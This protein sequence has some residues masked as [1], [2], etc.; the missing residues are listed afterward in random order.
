MYIPV[1]FEDA[2]FRKPKQRAGLETLYAGL[3]ISTIE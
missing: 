2:R 3:L 1:P